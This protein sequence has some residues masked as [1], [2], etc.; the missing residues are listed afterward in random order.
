M[1]S[2]STTK[3]GSEQPGTIEHKTSTPLNPKPYKP[4]KLHVKKP[5]DTWNRTGAA[6]EAR[7][8]LSCDILSFRAESALD[9]CGAGSR[10]Y[11]LISLSV[12][13]LNNLTQ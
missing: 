12:S 13:G 5:P 8:L 3:R 10:T 7:D 9:L 6:K 2:N 1:R 4:P 11:S